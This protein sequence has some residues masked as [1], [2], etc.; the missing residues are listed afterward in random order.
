M[1]YGLPALVEFQA[2]LPM[3]NI[4]TSLGRKRVSLQGHQ[5]AN[6]HSALTALRWASLGLCALSLYLT[7]CASSGVSS[8]ESAPRIGGYIDAGMQKQF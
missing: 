4:R 5:T 7:G 3:Q 8:P 2:P 6:G 1:N